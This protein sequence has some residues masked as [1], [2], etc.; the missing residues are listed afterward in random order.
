MKLNTDD[1]VGNEHAM[2]I[3]FDDLRDKINLTGRKAKCIYCGKEV[4]SNWNLLWFR[5][6]PYKINDT[7]Y[8]GCGGWD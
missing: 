1:A 3:N 7:Y 5:Y 4:D 6:Y 8:C 2:S